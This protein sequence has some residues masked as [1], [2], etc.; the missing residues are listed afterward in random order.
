MKW[1]SNGPKVMVGL[2]A[3]FTMRGTSP[4]KN[5][6]KHFSTLPMSMKKTSYY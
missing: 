6:N 5:I 3:G 1:V 4:E 2:V